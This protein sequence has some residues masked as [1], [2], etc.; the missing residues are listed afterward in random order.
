MHQSM[1]KTAFKTFYAEAIATF[2]L[3]L[4]FK[5]HAFLALPSSWGLEAAVLYETIDFDDQE[6]PAYDL[7][8]RALVGYYELQNASKLSSK[9][10]LTLIDFRRSANQKR[11]WVI[12]LKNRRLLYHSLTA[13]G[14]NSGDVFARNFSNTPNSNQ[15]SLGFYVTGKTY[16]GKHGISLKLHGV[17]AGINDKAE[18]RAIVMHGAAY[19]SDSYIK[20]FGR[21]GRSFGCPAVP[22]ELHKEIIPTLAEGTCLFIY[23]PDPGYISKTKFR[24]SNHTI[25]DFRS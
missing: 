13:H 24:D 8:Q 25:D 15:S 18:A 16:F 1:R 3:L 11:L 17:E 9:G 2:I 14:R 12:D 10:I 4:T 20:K 5:A 7:F 21:L 6:P 19:V 22:M 23:Y